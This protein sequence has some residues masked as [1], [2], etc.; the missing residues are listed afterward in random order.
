[1]ELLSPENI[2]KFTQ[3]IAFRLFLVLALVQTGILVAFMYATVQ[4]QQSH[5][6]ENVVTSAL[7]V[8]DMIARSTRYSMLLNRKDDVHNI[9]SSVA[10]QPGIEG[11]RIYNKLGQVIFSANSAD[12]HATVDMNAEACVSC[13]GSS[14]LQSPHVAGGDLSRIFTK[15]GGERILGL[16][17]PIRN[18][19]QCSDAECHAHPPDKTILGV[20]DV[21]MSLTQVDRRLK[22]SRDQLLAL[23]GG[24]V[25][26]IALISGGFIWFVV[27]R[28]VKR[29]AQGMERVSSGHLG[30]RLEVGSSD[31]LGR[32][33][34]SFNR[35]TGELA[36]AQEELTSWS[37]TLEEKVKEK[38]ADLERAHRQIVRVEK[39]ASLGNLAATVAH[40]LNNPLE[41]ILTFAKLLIRRIQKT[42]LPPE[43]AQPLCDDLRLVADEAQRCGNIVKNLLVFSRQRGGSFQPVSITSIVERCMLL[44]HHHAEMHGVALKAQP[45]EEAIVECDASQIQQALMALMVNGIEAM[46][47]AGEKSRGGEMTVTVVRSSVDGDV[48]LK[49]S[50][51][52]VGMS[53]DV[54]AH[55]FEPFFTTKSE[56]KGV[57]LGLS[58][59]YGIIQSH[60]GSIDVISAA[61]KGTTFIMT[62]PV[63]QPATPD[64]ASPAGAEGAFAS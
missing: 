8:S 35:M 55:I 15:P 33:A 48:I 31:E 19:Q 21:K 29:L 41:G 62:L 46:A 34:A 60:H 47:P 64:V 12:I 28:P 25:L 61:G 58:V 30:E 22:E 56:G 63:K 11:L 3:T 51:T 49:V 2:M 37:N 54:K 10:G 27:Q 6:M 1:V 59:V 32:L 39:L 52:G 40:E 7:R 50:D 9:V 4:V 14:G 53:E 20:L 36:R 16:I 38:T 18:E 5:L 23:S 17:T 45:L 44:M 26:L 24:A 43:T 57:G 13:H 42:G